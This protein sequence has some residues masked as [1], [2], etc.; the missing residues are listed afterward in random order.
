MMVRRKGQRA[1]SRHITLSILMAMALHISSADS[2]ELP[3]TYV[4]SK[5]HQDLQ[6]REFY[7]NILLALVCMLLYS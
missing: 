2:S 3:G 4:D 6:Q 1:A 7:N 5:L